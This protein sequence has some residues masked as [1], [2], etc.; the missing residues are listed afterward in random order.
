MTFREVWFFITAY[1]GPNGT[2][3]P[4]GDIRVKKDSDLAF[5]ITP[6]PGYAPVALLDGSPVMLSE[7][8]R[9]QFINIDRDY[10][11]SVTFVAE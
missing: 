11:L 7:D 8:N 6:D 3:D 4:S 9:F 10:A 5:A 2:I 1:A